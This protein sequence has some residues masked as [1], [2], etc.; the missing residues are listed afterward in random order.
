MCV[1]VCISG[2]AHHDPLNNWE[3]LVP[4][5]RSRCRLAL[6]HARHLNPPYIRAMCNLLLQDVV[7]KRVI[8]FIDLET[9]EDGGSLG[10]RDG[11]SA[12]IQY[13]HI[14]L[15]VLSARMLF[16]LPRCSDRV[17]GVRGIYTHSDWIVRIM[18][19]CIITIICIH[20]VNNCYK[21]ILTLTYR[22]LYNVYI[23]YSSVC[24]LYRVINIF[25]NKIFVKHDR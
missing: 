18:L 17:S 4:F 6:I 10:A 23:V 25:R 16:C 11:V 15:C 20:I 2:A 7:D 12:A 19:L 9:K 22:A 24:I 14:I 3:S 21:Y 13:Y 5:S 1:C 8:P